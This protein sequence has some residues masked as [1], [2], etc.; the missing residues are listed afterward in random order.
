MRK[1][2]SLSIRRLTPIYICLAYF[3]LLVLCSVSIKLAVQKKRFS[4]NESK[5]VM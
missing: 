5:V 4:Y 3:A 2:T 1:I